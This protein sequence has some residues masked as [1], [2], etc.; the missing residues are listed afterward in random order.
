[1]ELW[2]ADDFDPWEAL[3]WETVR[4]IRYWQHKPGGEI[5]EA[6]W[7][8]NLPRRQVSRRSFYAM[9]KSR[10]LIENQGFNPAWAGP[11]TATG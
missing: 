4:V 9:A 5:V 2:E 3:R 11:R 8:T 1:V 7:L 10:W 6:Y